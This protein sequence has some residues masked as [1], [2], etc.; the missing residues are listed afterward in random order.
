MRA[1]NGAWRL[2]SLVLKALRGAVQQG[3]GVLF[4][5]LTCATAAMPTHSL[6]ELAGVKPSSSGLGSSKPWK[7]FF[8]RNFC[9]KSSELE[10]V[11]IAFAT[12]FVAYAT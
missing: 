10:L 9:K 5:R 4:Q 8:E 1:F 2:R 11:N 7:G 12:H 6:E 3:K